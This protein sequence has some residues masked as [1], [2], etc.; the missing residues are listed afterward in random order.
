MGKITVEKER[1]I[2]A[3]PEKIFSVLSNYKEQRPRMLTP[4]FIDYKVEKGGKGSGTVISYLLRAANRERAYRMSVDEAVKGRVLTERDNNSSLVTTWALS[5]VSGGDKTR[6]SVASEWEGGKGVGG[7]FERTFAPLGLRRIY[8]S[9]LTSLIDILGVSGEEVTAVQG[10]EYRPTENLRGLILI[11]SL[12]VGFAF[13]LNYIQ[14]ANREK[15]Q[16]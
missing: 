13:G 8:G 16:R 7:F 9:M 5:P 12:V 2:N 6:V 1:V 3:S 11:L 15:A 10:K 4:N 14:K